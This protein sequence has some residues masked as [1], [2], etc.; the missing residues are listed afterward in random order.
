MA[1]TARKKIEKLDDSTQL[2]S[3]YLRSMGSIPG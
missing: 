1:I 2:L 3:K